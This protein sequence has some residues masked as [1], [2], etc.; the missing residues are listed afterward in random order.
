MQN[1]PS[2]SHKHKE[3][4]N[5][6]KEYEKRAKKVVQSA[7]RSKK[8]NDLQ[9]VAGALFSQDKVELKDYVLYD[10]IVPLLKDGLYKIGNSALGM[11]LYGG[12]SK[13]KTT[14]NGTKFSY[15]G[16]D[17]NGVSKNKPLS[18][19][20]NTGRRIYEYDDI[21]FTSRSDA[22]LVLMQLDELIDHFN[23]VRIADL[24]EAAGV[25][26]EDWTVT[27]YGWDDITSARIDRKMNGKFV[28]RMPKPIPID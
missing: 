23:I 13:G 7:V 27:D 5:K 6:K 25:T 15:G 10:V 28:I 20:S 4:M 18:Y 19:S 26:P 2:N 3:E 9:K 12:A 17:Y 16:T 8:K 11:I 14:L 21:E 24:Y 1:Y 22:E